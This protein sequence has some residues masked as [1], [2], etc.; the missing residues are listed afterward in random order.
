MCLVIAATGSAANARLLVG[1]STHSGEEAILAE[2]FL[3]LRARFPDLF[4]VLVPRHFERGR[5]V[6]RELSARA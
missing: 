4:L 3:R 2:Q 1:G 6:G 5:E